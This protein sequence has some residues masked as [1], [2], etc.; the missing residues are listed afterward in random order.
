[1]RIGIF[2]GTFNPIHK[3][4]VHIARAFYREL[5]LDRL[6]VIPTHVPVHKMAGNLISGEERM[7]LCWLAVRDDPNFEVSGIEVESEEKSYTYTTV[8]KLRALYPTAEFFFFIGSDMFLSFHTWYHYR[9]ILQQVT[10][11]AAARKDK[12]QNNLA[13]CARQL[14]EE[15]GRCIVLDLDVIEI[16]S[17]QLREKIRRGE[18]VSGYLDP[19]VERYIRE[20][21]L[22]Q[23]GT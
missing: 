20:K 10:L 7:Q 8:K 22:Y 18:D 2:G 16:S 15:G 5:D 1:M 17:T 14:T 6:L 3:G 19:E 21:R 4:H 12:E 11:C 23:N 13:A 9:D